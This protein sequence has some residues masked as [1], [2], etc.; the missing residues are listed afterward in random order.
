MRA[1]TLCVVLLGLLIAPGIT[2]T[3]IMLLASFAALTCCMIALGIGFVYAC[4]WIRNTYDDLA[5]ARKL[6]PYHRRRK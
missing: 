5:Y 2:T 6:W 4:F 1:I 3:A